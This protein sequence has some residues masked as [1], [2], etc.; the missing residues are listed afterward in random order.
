MLSV[1]PVHLCE[2]DPHS[3]RVVVLNANK[4]ETDERVTYFRVVGLG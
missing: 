4:R 2:R 1:Q 3:I